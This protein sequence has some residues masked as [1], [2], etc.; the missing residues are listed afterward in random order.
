MSRSLRLQPRR[1]PAVLLGVSQEILFAAYAPKSKKALVPG[2]PNRPFF[3]AT[4]DSPKQLSATCGAHLA[5][6]VPNES[7]ELPITAA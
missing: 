2:S 5:L 6:G 4:P 7:E 3:A 1:S